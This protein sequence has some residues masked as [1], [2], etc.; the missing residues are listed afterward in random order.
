MVLALKYT[1]LILHSLPFQRC[2]SCIILCT[3][4]VTTRWSLLLWSFYRWVT[5]RWEVIFPMSERQQESKSR[6]KFRSLLDRAQPSSSSF[7]CTASLSPFS[8][9]GKAQFWKAFHQFIDKK[10]DY[11]LNLIQTKQWQT[12]FS[13]APK[14]LWMV[15]AAMKLKDIYLLLERKDKTNLDSVL[16][17]RDIT[18]QTKVRTVKALVS[19]VVV[20]GCENWTIKKVEH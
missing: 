15:M 8:S 7:H 16:K 17:I 9:S 13:W 1:W 18:S 6:F 10:E 20:Y 3:N 5:R 14:S 12:L 4:N 11:T 2:F 19:I